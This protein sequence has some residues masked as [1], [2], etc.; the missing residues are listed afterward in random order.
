[1]KVGCG[2]G[3]GVAENVEKDICTIEPS[4]KII[5]T[6]KSLKRHVWGSNKNILFRKINQEEKQNSTK[7]WA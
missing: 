4:E 5:C 7:S 2:S 6:P 3:V 1:M